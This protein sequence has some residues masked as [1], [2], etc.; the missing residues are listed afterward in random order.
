MP[1]L[2]LAA[3]VRMLPA[4]VV[5]PLDAAQCQA[6]LGPVGQYQAQLA[7]AEASL[8]K[9]AAKEKKY[10][11]SRNR[12]VRNK[13]RNKYAHVKTVVGDEK[14]SLKAAEK[15]ETPWCFIPQ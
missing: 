1:A 3:F 6:A 8:K 7:A 12:K 9:A 10:G 5:R 4:A 13:V 2:G 11:E 14:Q 15:A